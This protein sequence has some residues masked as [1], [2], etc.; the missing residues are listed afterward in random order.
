MNNQIIF[1]VKK[2]IGDIN[3]KCLSAEAISR[4]IVA[5]DRLEQ[6]ST[7]ARTEGLLMMDEMVETL[8]DEG[9]DGYFKYLITLVSDGIE[10]ETL[11]ECG[12]LKF[13]Q[14]SYQKEETFICLMY[15][16]CIPMIHQAEYGAMTKN[17]D[18]M[19]PETVRKKIIEREES[20]SLSLEEELEEKIRKYS[21]E[22]KDLCEL[23]YTEQLSSVL[24]KFDEEDILTVIQDPH[25]KFKNLVI[26]T[27]FMPGNTKKRIFD[28]LPSKAYLKNLLFE[29]DY[30]GLM[31]VSDVENNSKHILE[32][33]AWLMEINE[34][35]RTE[36]E[37]IKIV[38]D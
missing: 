5:R 29:M 7:I 22:N 36:Y 6:Y 34:I 32:C 33:I 9:C 23:P 2:A 20:N 3:S 18:A 10:V 12:L 4:I 16:N 8:P 14:N 15:L 31:R 19:L 28:N 37:S 21:G 27:K 11:K 30:L 24:N 26:A 1:E 13:Y 35:S 25:I 38:L 17:L